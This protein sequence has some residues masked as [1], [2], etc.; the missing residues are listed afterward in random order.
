M[1][2]VPEATE[3]IIERSRYLSEALSKDLINISSL[4]RYIKPELEEMVSKKISTSAIIMALKR[5]NRKF[6][7]PTSFQNLFIKTP[8]FTVHSGNGSTAS[9]TI[10][11]QKEHAATPGV[12]YFFLKSLAWERINIESI[13]SGDYFLTIVVDDKDINRTFSVLKSLF[14]NPQA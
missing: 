5:L 10:H 3:K 4:A 14:N 2:T 11:L 9:I 7:T 12:Y 6:E 1:L 13:S 8:E